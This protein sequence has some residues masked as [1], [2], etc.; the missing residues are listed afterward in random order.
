MFHDERYQ[1][2]IKAKEAVTSP[3]AAKIS[4]RLNRRKRLFAKYI[5]HMTL[6]HNCIP[7]IYYTL[8]FII[9]L[10]FFK[11]KFTLALL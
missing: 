6:R 4:A 9:I 2:N 10:P 11:K 7:V 1:S 3:T 5:Q 8:L